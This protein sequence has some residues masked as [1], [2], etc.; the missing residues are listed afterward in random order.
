VG[1]PEDEVHVV[2]F[3]DRYKPQFHGSWHGFTGERWNLGI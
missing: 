2:G 1:L 3:L